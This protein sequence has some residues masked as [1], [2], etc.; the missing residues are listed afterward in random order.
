M[1]SG[2]LAMLSKQSLRPFLFYALSVALGKGLSL[3]TLPVLARHLPP[4]DFARLDMAA[5]VIE[6]VGLIAGLALADTLFRF[7][8]ADDTARKA[9]MRR[10]LGLG[11][12]IAFALCVLVQIV[13]VPLILTRPNMPGEIA[14]RAILAAASFG[15]LIELPL[16]FLRL[17]GKPLGFLGFVAARSLGQAGLLI[18]L[19][20]SGYGVDALLMG[21]ALLDGL[22]ITALL[23][24]LPKGIG[25]AF[26]ASV[27]GIPDIARYGGPLLLGGLAMFVLGACDRWFL[28]GAVEPTKLAHYALAAKLA[29][30]LALAMQPFALWWY[31]RRL[32]VLNAP[33]GAQKTARFWFIGLALIGASA[34]LAMGAARVLVLGFL[35]ESYHGAVPY[36]PALL[37]IVALNEIASLS[38]G[39]SY[40]HAHGWRVLSVNSIGAGV[41][42]LLYGLLIPHLGLMGAIIATILAQ[43]VR[44]VLFIRERWQGEVLHN[45]LGAGAMLLLL[46]FSVVSGLASATF[47][48]ML[49]GLMAGASVLAMALIAVML[50]VQ[51]RFFVRYA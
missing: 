43:A 3:V 34:V 21:N 8:Q 42:L 25:R 47:T 19:L 11:L 44:V 9:V 37:L 31:P 41:A 46:C 2:V 30:A 40:A 23:L 6:P 14:L 12:L 13:V 17:H 22:I 39:A 1:L 26:D 20:Q 51:P 38:N 15:G 16:A 48:P 36:L 10:L 32:A 18:V 27:P 50:I 4:E 29:L 28:A 49:S 5:S 33:D 45:P 24:T 35:P 7:A